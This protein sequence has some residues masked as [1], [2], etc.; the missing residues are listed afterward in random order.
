MRSFQMVRH[1]DASGVSGTGLVAQGVEFDD[2]TCVLRWMTQFK[3]TAFY[4]S[5]ADL[6]AVHGHG[7]KTSIQWQEGVPSLVVN[8]TAVAEKISE[9]VD[10]G[11]H[12]AKALQDMQAS[13]DGAY[14]ERDL[15]VALLAALTSLMEKGE[16]SEGATVVTWTAWL[17]KHDPADTS[18]DPEWTNIVFLETPTGQMSWHIHDDELK[19]FFHLPRPTF[20]PGHRRRD[21][22]S[23]EEKYE[24]LRRLIDYLAV[25]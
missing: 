25:A 2:G 16:R 18:W 20:E 22:H 6:E 14:R 9:L 12:L 5:A 17:G 19:L 1:E 21:G 23:T 13:K 8:D 4:A 7:G 3:S 24:R 11:Y 15:C 10:R